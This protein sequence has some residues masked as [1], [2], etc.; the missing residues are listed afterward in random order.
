AISTGSNADD[1]N[2]ADGQALKAAELLVAGSNAN[3]PRTPDDIASGVA[4][5]VAGALEPNVPNTVADATTHDGT[6]R[7]VN[8]YDVTTALPTG[9]ELPAVADRTSH[10]TNSLGRTWAE[11]VGEDNIMMERV[12][13][14]NAAVPVASI[15]GF[16]AA[17]TLPNDAPSF[18]TNTAIA[19][20]TSYTS[21]ANASRYRGIPGSVWC[22]GSDCK[23]VD[24][25]LTG[26]W[27]FTPD[28]QDDYYV[29]NRNNPD[30]DRSNLYERDNDY[31][32]YGHWLAVATSGEVTVHT[33]AYLP[34]ASGSDP[35]GNTAN[36]RLGEDTADGAVNTATYTGEAVGMSVHKTFDGNAKRTGIHSGAFTADVTLNATFGATATLSGMVKNF[37]G[38]THT[39]SS[40]TVALQETNL[41]AAAALSG[42][43]GVA[44]GSG[45]A[46]DWTAQGHGPSTAAD[47]Q[48]PTGFF[49][50][51]ESHFTDGHASGAYAARKD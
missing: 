41:T 39:D 10:G 48:R 36:L 23:I 19:D 2:N 18:G 8:Y 6:A 49:G 50:N 9:A 26:S 16:T 28:S 14:N 22:L 21:A 29:L 1:T 5:A 11:I 12:G 35:A 4:M 43:I 34:G 38:G 44:K 24:G 42:G 7:R 27:Y 32:I 15:A 17:E 30:P 46:G 25:I 45:Q 47:P 51:F 3:K 13:A 37:Q 31:V 40:W 20:A 33:Y